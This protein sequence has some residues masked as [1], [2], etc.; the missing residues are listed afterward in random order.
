MLFFAFFFSKNGG[1][2]MMEHSY[3]PNSISSNEQYEFPFWIQ[4]VLELQS[5]SMK[6][7][8]V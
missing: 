7:G 1:Q 5:Q 6:L 3:F 2:L 8:V 4:I